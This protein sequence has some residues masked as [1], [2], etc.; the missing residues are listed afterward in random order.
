MP[1]IC[2]DCVGEPV[3]RS[4]VIGE[5]STE[6][7]CDYCESE[8]PAADLWRV[9]EKCDY[10]LATFFEDSSQT[11]AVVHFGR[12]PAGQDASETIQRLAVVS[13]EIASDIIGSLQALWYDGDTGDSRYVDDDPW[14]VLRSKFDSPLLTEWTNIESSLRSEA[15]YINPRVAA[16][17]ETVFGGISSDRTA[18]GESLLVNAGPGTL[19]EAFYRA[20]EFPS[21]H[22]IANALEHPEKSLGAPPSGVGPGGRM[23]AAGLPAFYGAT[24]AETALAEV[25]PAVGSSVVVAKFS[26]VRPLKLLDLKLM[27]RVQLERSASLFDEATQTLA[28]RHEFLRHLSER[29]TLPVIP[30]GQERNYLVTQV[31]ADYLAMHPTASIDGIIYPSV[32]SGKGE[33]NDGSENVV[34]FHKAATAIDAD[35]EVS[36]AEAE[37]WEY[38]EDGPD[39]YFR[40]KIFYKEVRQRHTF[41]QP[42]FRPRPAL[43]LMID[44]IVIHR[45]LSV[46]IKTDPIGVEVVSD[47]DR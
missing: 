19:Y 42:G 11:M 1:Y 27:S 9:A 31:V 15:R 20:R 33:A 39:E 25:R 36:T 46:S 21:D 43:R 28:Q 22:D 5:A 30:K 10:V 44:S 7:P 41:Q 6:N 47:R 4:F 12:T 37:L 14:F 2:P 32:Q 8:L 34:L 23:N 13:E 35:S 3:L 24:K 26:V 38:D 18:D 29:M 40:P 16:F 45:V 17:M